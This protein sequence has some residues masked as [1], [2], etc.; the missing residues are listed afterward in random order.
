MARMEVMTE[1]KAF[2]AQA[3]GI[4]SGAVR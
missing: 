4:R 2:I 3:K 1:E